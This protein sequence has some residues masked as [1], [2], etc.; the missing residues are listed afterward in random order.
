MEYKNAKNGSNKNWN[1]MAR[2]ILKKGLIWKR[3]FW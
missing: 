2:K 3:Y 1:F